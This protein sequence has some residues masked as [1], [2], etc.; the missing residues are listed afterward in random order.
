MRKK[1]AMRVWRQAMSGMAAAGILGALGVMSPAALADTTAGVADKAAKAAEKAAESAKEAAGAAK[2]AEKQLTPEERKLKDMRSEIERLRAEYELKTQRQKNAMLDMELERQRIQS[3]SE[4]ERLQREQAMADMRAEVERLQAEQ[5]LK[6]ARLQQRLGEMKAEMERIRAEKQLEEARRDELLAALKTEADR[7]NT[8]NSLL[9]AQ[10]A[11]KE[12]ELNAARMDFNAE[13]N[14]LETGVALRD[15]KDEVATRVLEDISYR[16]NP[17]EG[18]TLYVSDRRIEL[19]GP[20]MTGTADYVTDRIHFYNNQDPE[21]PIF[22]VIDDSPGGS[23]MQGYRIV[24]AIERSDAPVHVLVKSF[25]ASM[26]AVITTLAPHSY[27]YPN[28][29]ILHHEMSYG[30]GG[31]MTEHKEQLEMAK[32]W[33]RRLAEP[34]AHKMGVSLDRLRELMYENNSNGDWEEFATEAVG[35]KWVD[36]V[37]D[38]VREDGI[39]EQPTDR[40]PTPWF[41]FLTADADLDPSAAADLPD[42][43]ADQFMQ[44]DDKGRLYVQLPPLRPFDYYW[45]YDPADMYRW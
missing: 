11:K 5:Q 20:I 41:F 12:L 39:R 16:T 32:E 15:K 35:L 14:E 9:S 44:R 45:I 19:N 24:K 13:V 17:L 30:M 31:N 26:A 36:H 3:K 42:Y 27:A 37:V 21:L 10:L 43:A 6:D 2:E 25:A 8:R 1:K 34:V 38:E 4:F 23:V 18:D 33:E 40:A 7:L 29:I 22:I 28:A